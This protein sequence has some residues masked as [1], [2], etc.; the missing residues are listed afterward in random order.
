MMRNDTKIYNK[1]NLGLIETAA[2]AKNK[3]VKFINLLVTL[4]FGEN[5]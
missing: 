3:G 2:L 4:L 5:G 1:N